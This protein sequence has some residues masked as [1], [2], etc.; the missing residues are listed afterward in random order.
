MQEKRK[1][2]AA[3]HRLKVDWPPRIVQRKRGRQGGYHDGHLVPHRLGD[4]VSGGQ[5]E[6]DFGL[7]VDCG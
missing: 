1:K 5:M 7:G 6:P 3:S 4:P 2:K